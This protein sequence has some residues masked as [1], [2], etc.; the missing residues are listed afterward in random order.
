MAGSW[1]NFDFHVDTKQIREISVTGGESKVLFEGPYLFL[2]L[3]P[4]GS[5]FATNLQN[6][7][8]IIGGRPLLIDIATGNV[9]SL[10]IDTSLKSLFLEFIPS[11][12]SLVFY[13]YYKDSVDG[14][15][16]T[17]Y[18]WGAFYAFDL[19]TRTNHQLFTENP[20]L[21]AGM[22]ITPDGKK[23][24]TAG[25]IR[26]IDGTGVKE[27]TNVGIWQTLSPSGDTVVGGFGLTVLRSTYVV[28]AYLPSDSLMQK[29]WLIET[30]RNSYVY[31]EFSL[32]P[33]G[34][35]LALCIASRL[36]GGSGHDY[37]RNA[38][39]LLTSFD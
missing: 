5:T 27:V 2:A 15:Y 17:N 30:E 7:V 8:G 11:G 39:Y 1:L 20:L 19:N 38:I 28:E 3:S 37:G 26:N 35:I 36:S 25:K 10:P 32:S 18:Y 14:N 21:V 24:V 29:L 31:S 16:Q 4:D 9:D 22:A 13:A 6:T 23:I 33:D 12:D 34:Q